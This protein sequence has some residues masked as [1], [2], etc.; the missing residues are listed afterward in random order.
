[1]DNREIRKIA[2]TGPYGTYFISLPK[3]MIRKLGWRKGEKKI[4]H[5]EDKRI[6]IEDWKR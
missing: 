6:I 1:M 3:E 2:V 4:I 5:L